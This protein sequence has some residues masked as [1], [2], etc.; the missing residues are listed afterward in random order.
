MNFE[1]ILYEVDSGR[2]PITLNRPEKRNAMS[3]KLLEELN[4]A[5]WE[6]DHD[7]RVHAVI[8]R[9]ISDDQK[10]DHR[11]D[12]PRPDDRA[13]PITK[14]ES[15]P[16]PARPDSREPQGSRQLHGKGWAHALQAHQQT[17]GLPSP[18]RQYTWQQYKTNLRRQ[19]ST[20]EA[21]EWCL[22]KYTF[23]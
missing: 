4:V 13:G 23:S 16:D 11:P 2:A 21:D 19:S 9:G 14:P 15:G 1:H 18:I 7:T 6:A 12:R 5:L 3:R 20:I 17:G 8:L 10:S 22:I